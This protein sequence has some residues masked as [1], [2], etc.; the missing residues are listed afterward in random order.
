MSCSGVLSGQCLASVARSMV[1]LHIRDMGSRP[2]RFN[3]KIKFVSKH[4]AAGIYM[5]SIDTDISLQI[6]IW[7]WPHGL[8]CLP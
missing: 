3:I 8:S 5:C 4:G 2:E 6:H 7:P 1:A